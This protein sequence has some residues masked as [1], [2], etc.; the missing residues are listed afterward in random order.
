MICS[1]FVRRALPALAAI[2]ATAAAAR[3]QDFSGVG[4]DLRW[5]ALLDSAALARAAAELPA[6]ELPRNVPPIFVVTFDTTGAAWEVRPLSDR[7]PASYAEPVMAALRANARPQA[8]FARPYAVYVRVVTGPDARVDSPPLVESQ[9]VLVNRREIAQ[10]LSRATGRHALR[11]ASEPR[12]RYEVDVKFRIRADGTPEA[13]SATVLHS[14][15]DPG[16][17]DEAL[18]VVSAM[19]FRPATVEGVPVRVWVTL[20]IHFDFP[21]ERP[22]STRPRS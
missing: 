4:R 15:G 21:T 18:G 11:L 6:G 9:P 10:A 3:A 14:S 2:C 8:P 16:L 17:D 20:P 1:I 12:R 7:V 22:R 19:R 5:S 13:A